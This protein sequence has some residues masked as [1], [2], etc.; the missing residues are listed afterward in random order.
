MYGNRHSILSRV[1]VLLAL[2]SLALPTIS[3][4]QFAPCTVTKDISV[5]TFSGMVPQSGSYVH[6]TFDGSHNMT[7]W[8]VRFVMVSV[9]G[10]NPTWGLGQATA[11][12]TYGTFQNLTVTRSGT[13]L[14]GSASG[15][16]LS[17]NGGWVRIYMRDLGYPSYIRIDDRNDKIADWT[18]SLT[19]A[20]TSLSNFVW[21]LQY[22]ATEGA[23]WADIPGATG[24]YAATGVG[25]PQVFTGTWISMPV[26]GQVQLVKVSGPSYTTST[27][28]PQTYDA[29]HLSYSNYATL[30]T[31]VVVPYTIN[32][33]FSSAVRTDPTTV[34]LVVG[35]YV[36]P[37]DIIVPGGTPNVTGGVSFAGIVQG[38]LVLDLP[39]DVRNLPITATFIT[40]GRSWNMFVQTS[41]TTDYASV[42]GTL[43]ASSGANPWL[44]NVNTDMANEQIDSA[45]LNPNPAT[46]PTKAPTQVTTPQSPDL[47]GEIPPTTFGG[48]S[49]QN[50]ATGM[51]QDDIAVGVFKGQMAA[52]T[53]LG[54]R[55]LLSSNQVVNAIGKYSSQ[56]GNSTTDF[57]SFKAGYTPATTPGDPTT[58]DMQIDASSVIALP[59]TPA[60]VSTLIFDPNGLAGTLNAPIMTFLSLV[61]DMLSAAA[62]VGFVIWLYTDLTERVQMA[63]ATP[64]Q[65]GIQ[66]GG[67]SWWS[68]PG[69][70]IVIA[71]LLISVIAT[72]MLYL[73]NVGLNIGF[74]S[75]VNAGSAL[76]NFINTGNATST[77][78]RW[79]YNLV[80]SVIDLQFML[81][82]MFATLT[83]RMSALVQSMVMSA[84]LK[85]AG[86]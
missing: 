53:E 8:N 65:R 37:N 6:S 27:S 24:S 54:M 9:M 71:L 36:V 72:A 34:R 55:G 66:S 28:D 32:Y 19:V 50:T 57:D 2:L 51:N 33:S 64:P 84:A 22:R 11:A 12:P 29:A 56:A 43:Y 60:G 16:S 83:Y 15:F 76:T 69:S 61:R 82:L 78:F 47:S 63:M 10:F 35:D 79:S 67:G 70:A 85:I 40:A 38:K 26:G 18:Y 23:V 30:A 4:A 68:G 86:T 39:E 45:Q 31:P 58:S 80:N 42:R 77:A 21:K 75:P 1:L 74:G 46:T 20:G 25:T 81:V 59:S 17:F 44:N 3:Y 62:V 41:R 13:V 73:V 49:N 48:T 14:T 52:A 5:S 7:A